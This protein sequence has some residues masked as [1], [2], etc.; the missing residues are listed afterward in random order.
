MSEVTSEGETFQGK[1]KAQPEI[2]LEVLRAK[3]KK[4]TPLL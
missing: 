2:S 4:E 1:P 3:P